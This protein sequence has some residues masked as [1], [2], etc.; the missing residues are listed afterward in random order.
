MINISFYFKDLAP[1]AI[2]RSPNSK[3]EFTYYMKL[4]PVKFLFHSFKTPSLYNLK[5]NKK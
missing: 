2:F 5:I 3:G 4:V 1:G